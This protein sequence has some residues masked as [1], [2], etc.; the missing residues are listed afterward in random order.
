[1]KAQKVDYREYL[2]SPEWKAKRVEVLARARGRCE[3]CR[4]APAKDVHHKTYARLGDEK[5]S[6]LAVLCR[7]CHLDEHQKPRST[8]RQRKRQLKREGWPALAPEEQ[9]HHQRIMAKTMKRVAAKIERKR[10]AFGEF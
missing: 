1:M 4:K 9:E 8:K 5:L 10:K 7:N 6:D 2:H 3:R